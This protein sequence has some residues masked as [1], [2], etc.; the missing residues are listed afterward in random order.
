L[1]ALQQRIAERESELEALRRQLERRRKRLDALTRRK[2]QLQARLHEVE[3]E[4][5][6]LVEGAAALRSAR[7][8]PPGKGPRTLAD[9]LVAILRDTD[10]PLTVRQ[11]VAELEARG[12]RTTSANL[13]NLVKAR[14]YELVHRGVLRRPRGRRGFTVG[15]VASRGHQAPEE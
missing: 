6:A 14:A 3:A 1:E 2:E 11:L 15:K 10:R 5:A 9:H 4:I 12:F 8:A 7:A 13:A